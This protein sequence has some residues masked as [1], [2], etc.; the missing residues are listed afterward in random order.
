MSVVVD[1]VD[2]FIVSHNIFDHST[3][4]DTDENQSWWFSFLIRSSLFLPH[5]VIDV[6]LIL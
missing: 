3:L 4:F 6:V 1:T 5:N 2:M